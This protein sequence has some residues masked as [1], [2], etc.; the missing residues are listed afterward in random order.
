MTEG[1]IVLY[2]LYFEA[3][4]L[5][6]TEYDNIVSNEARWWFCPYGPD[7]PSPSWRRMF[8][9]FGESK[10]VVADGIFKLNRRGLAAANGRRINPC[11]FAAA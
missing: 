9:C 6:K 10:V 5:R 11:H 8:Q 1:I 7:P 4:K 2:A 3:Y